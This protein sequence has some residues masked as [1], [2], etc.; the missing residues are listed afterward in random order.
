MLRWQGKIGD[1]LELMRVA[2]DELVDG[3]PDRD[4]A[5]VAAQYG[6]LAYFA[7]EPDMASGPVEMAIEIGEAL[8]LPE[9]LAEALNTKACLLWRRA[10]EAEAL[11]MQSL[12][13]AM[14]NGLTSASLRAQFNLSGTVPRTRSAGAGRA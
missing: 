11:L 10:N 7:G 8:D 1:A 12:K 13:V 9:P 4:L 2:Y 3:P 14:E 6:R 5:L